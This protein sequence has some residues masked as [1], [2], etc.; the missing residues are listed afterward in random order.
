MSGSRQW[1]RKVLIAYGKAD[2]TLDVMTRIQSIFD[3]IAA[4]EQ[5]IR[6]D[7]SIGLDN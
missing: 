1:P 5:V 2:M 6:D 3:Q 4:D 7:Q